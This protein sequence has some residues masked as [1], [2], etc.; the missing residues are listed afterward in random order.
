LAHVK[1]AE[2]KSGSL[3]V[4]TDLFANAD[5][6]EPAKAMCVAGSGYQTMEVGKF[7]GVIVRAVDGAR[8]VLRTELSGIC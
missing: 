3:W 4:Y 5:A 7:T 8:L 2:D 6:T 1:G